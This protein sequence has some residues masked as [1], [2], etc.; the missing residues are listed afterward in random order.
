[1]FKE[2]TIILKGRIPSWLIE[3]ENPRVIEL[4]SDLILENIPEN[5]YYKYT[6]D[7]IDFF[8]VVK[9]L[10]KCGHLLVGANKDFSL[11]IGSIKMGSYEKGDIQPIPIHSLMRIEFGGETIILRFR[12]VNSDVHSLF[13]H[14][15]FGFKDEDGFLALREGEIV[16]NQFQKLGFFDEKGNKVEHSWLKK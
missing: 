10:K 3:E 7:C 14:S 11:Y 8:K 9:E 15:N 13:F 4:E 2:G 6:F 16:E 1:M 12:K 5:E